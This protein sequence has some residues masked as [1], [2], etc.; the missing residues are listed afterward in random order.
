METKRE[1]GMNWETGIDKN[2]L[3]YMK[4]I[5]N[6]NLLCSTGNY[7]MI[8]GGLDGKESKCGYMYTCD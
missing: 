6:E 2:T 3:L 1:E 7:S 8:C 5:T 4:Q